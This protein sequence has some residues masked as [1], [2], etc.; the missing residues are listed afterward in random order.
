M[1]SRSVKS[2]KSEQLDEWSKNAVV[3]LSASM[4]FGREKASEI[5]KPL[6]MTL[7]SSTANDYKKA[8]EIVVEIDE[9]SV[10]RIFLEQ[11]KYCYILNTGSEHLSALVSNVDFTNKQM[12]ND[13]DSALLKLFNE[14]GKDVVLLRDRLRVLPIKAKRLALKRLY[15]KEFENFKKVK[16]RQRGLGDRV[17]VPII[18]NWHWILIF[19]GL[20]LFAAPRIEPF[21]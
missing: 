10:K 14:C 19:I 7:F 1:G 4:V 18:K 17:G 9:F 5:A 3:T 2:F 15:S 8:L 13:Y 21:N 6:L 12:S 20:V 11:F 16:I